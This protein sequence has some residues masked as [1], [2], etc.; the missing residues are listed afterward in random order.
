M[1]LSALA[2]S[3][4]C[5]NAGGP[6]AT[7]RLFND[8]NRMADSTRREFYVKSFSQRSGE[9]IF[10]KYCAVCHGDKGQG[11]GFN[12]FNL[13]PR[14][15]DLTDIK[16]MDAV[17][18]QRLNEI[19]SQGGSGT[20]KSV[21]MPSYGSTLSDDRIRDLIE[22]IRYIGRPADNDIPMSTDSSP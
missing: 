15:R 20:G 11:D 5:R 18:D 10:L 14:P 21:L 4:A 19:I 7:N 8:P 12:S 1:I 22:Y 2:I 13:D 9:K 3:P 16:Y 17:S 6:D